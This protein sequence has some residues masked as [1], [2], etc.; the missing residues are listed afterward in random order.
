[1]KIV[2]L[3]KPKRVVMLLAK[4]FIYPYID[5]RVYKEASSLARNGYEVS[6]VYWAKGGEALPQEERYEGIGVSRIFQAIPSPSVPMIL[7]VPA[8][9]KFVLKG[10]RK[11]LKLKPDIIHSHDLDTLAIG[12]ALKLITRK[13]L[14]FDAHEDF[15][16]MY[17]SKPDV[18]NSSG[19]T[20]LFMI[21]T[22]WMMRLYEKVLIRFANRVIA[23][24]LLYT[25]AMMKH[26]GITPAVILTLPNL[27]SFNP[28]VDASVII[29]QYQLEGKV[30][31]SQI[32]AIGE[33]RGIFETLEALQHL[34]YDNLR[35][36]LIGKTPAELRCK[37]KEAIDKY[38][39]SEKVI[40]LLD[41]IRYEDIP[42]YYKVSD[43]TMAL[44]YPV[45]TYVTSIPAKLYE[46][47]AMGVPVIAADLPHIRRIV[48][49][50]EVGLCAD[51]QD[52]G[53]IAEKLEVLISDHQ[54]RKR[55]GQ[56]GVK[57]AQEEFNWSQSQEKLLE[58]YDA[59]HPS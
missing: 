10:I 59:L 51:S 1:M 40:L 41:G 11:G 39:I 12:V 5:G 32:G 6:V 54:M 31:I 9:A 55:L 57:V 20:R 27:D 17:E 24:E 45:S 21:T 18:L 26:Y 13:P 37:I 44:L 38:N 28:T 15:P 34:N 52:S 50:Y 58:I 14:I 19:L 7:R 33:T 16:A 49:T 46:S 36:F 22:A 43:I 4:D 23:G 53:D 56:N 3:P 42:K 30:I 29:K 8:Y 47:L 2:S 48:D 35:C 25:E